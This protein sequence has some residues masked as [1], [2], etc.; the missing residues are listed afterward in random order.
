MNLEIT[1]NLEGKAADELMKRVDGALAVAM[2]GREIAQAS[3][4]N[5]EQSVQMVSLARAAIKATAK[6]QKSNPKTPLIEP[7][8]LV[9][10]AAMFGPRLMDVESG[11]VMQLQG[12]IK[13]LHEE[14]GLSGNE[15]AEAIM[16]L[17][18]DMPDS[19]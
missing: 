7:E 10:I 14:E 11:A 2:K 5:G 6:G 12:K 15:H 17:I 3:V 19:M 1:L 13:Q 16:K 9:K 4:E 8:N 18:R